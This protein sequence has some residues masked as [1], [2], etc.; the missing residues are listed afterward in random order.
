MTS[1]TSV[2]SKR[3]QSDWLTILEAPRAVA[4]TRL[5]RCGTAEPTPK[6]IGYRPNPV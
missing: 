5:G 4:I 3:D 1:L 6:E 2:T